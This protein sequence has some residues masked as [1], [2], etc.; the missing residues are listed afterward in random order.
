MQMEDTP[1]T[2]GRRQARLTAAGVRTQAGGA[3]ERTATDAYDK[4]PGTAAKDDRKPAGL[5]TPLSAEE[6]TELEMLRAE[7]ARLEQEL[8]TRQAEVVQQSPA[9][10]TTKSQQ[11]G[12]VLGVFEA[13]TVPKTATY[14]VGIKEVA[15]LLF[16]LG[17]LGY[18]LLHF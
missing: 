2:T 3:A 4:A 1:Q 13:L 9:L 12:A 8:S 10:G 7:R 11:M 15:L 16:I 18:L 6:R 17:F 14:E 5:S